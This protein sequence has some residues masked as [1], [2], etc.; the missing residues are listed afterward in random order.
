M[1]ESRCRVPRLARQGSPRVFR[2]IFQ[3]GTIVCRRHIGDRRGIDNRVS[4]KFN[5]R[6]LSEG[7]V[8]GGFVK[9][10]LA[11]IGGHPGFPD[12]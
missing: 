9:R 12:R 8:F 6:D 2:S 4:F 3:S 5:K 1:R 11:G 7:V 10:N